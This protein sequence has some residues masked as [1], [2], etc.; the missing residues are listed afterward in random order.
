MD[1]PLSA[2]I[3]ETLRYLEDGS[4]QTSTFD[5]FG[6]S[7]FQEPSC[8]LYRYR[9]AHQKQ[10]SMKV[11]GPNNASYEHDENM[12]R[13][14]IAWESDEN[15]PCWAD[16]ETAGA[17]LSL[18]NKEPVHPSQNHTSSHEQNPQTQHLTCAVCFE[19]L[20]HQSHP[21]S[22]ITAYCDHTSTPESHICT[23][24]L[25]R[26]MEIQLSSAGPNALLCPLCH[27]PFSDTEVH[28]WAARETFECYN[29]MKTQAAL[30]SDTEFIICPRQ[31]CGFGQLHAGG[32]EDPVVICGAC[33]TK[34]C[35]VHRDTIW[36]EGLSC[37]E[38]DEIMDFRTK[39][40]RDGQREDKGFLQW[41]RGKYCRRRIGS[42]D[43]QRIDPAME[44]L[45]SRR[46]L[47]KVT[48]PCP[49]CTI[50]TERTGGCK[51][52]RCKSM[53]GSRE[54]FLLLTVA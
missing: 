21:V 1:D 22:P 39:V 5:D 40:L 33:G 3:L 45:L 15:T 35:F 7:P 29:T 46:M 13:P 43:D 20:D 4:W 18:L 54:V 24:C 6:T 37:E 41:L 34:T 8:G 11:R 50:P 9:A 17:V 10:Q 49:S 38:Y 48:K 36:H 27:A 51:Y 25:Q 32:R 14:T 52:M 53:T 47:D 28:R 12:F 31:D 16:A 30:E 42:R 2:Q 26:S 23:P 44:D 19:S